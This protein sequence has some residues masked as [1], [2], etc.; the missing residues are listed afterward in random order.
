MTDLVKGFGV[1]DRSRPSRVDTKRERT[2]GV[3]VNMLD[4]ATDKFWEKYPTY[5]GTQ[6]SDNFKHYAY[7][8]DWCQDQ[9]GF[10]PDYEDVEWQLD[11]DILVKGN[12]LY[13]DDT[14]CFVP[15]EI[16]F[17]LLSNNANRGDCPIGVYYYKR[18]KSYMARY[19]AGKGITKYLGYFGTKEDAFIAYKTA[20]E[21]HIKSVAEYWKD[22]LDFRVYTAL[23]KYEVDITD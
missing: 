8:Y 20:K 11:K 1:N 5:R 7:F 13:S 21:A 18:T 3:W 10:N 16:N 6:I 14:C 2:Y 12:K 17:L 19:C 22:S 15:K 4:R 9:V 23:M